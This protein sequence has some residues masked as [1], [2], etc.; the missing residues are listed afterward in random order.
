MAKIRRSLKGGAPFCSVVIAAAGSS[1]RMDGE[2]KLFTMVCGAPVLAY[3]IGAFAKSGLVNEIIV[4]ARFDKLEQAGRLCMDYGGGKATKVITGGATRLDSVL[5]GVLA[6]SKKAK[7]IAVH[8]GAR[9][10]VPDEVVEHA[11]TAAASRQAVAPAVK[12]VSTLKRAEYRKVL[13]TVDRDKLFEIQTPQVFIS[14]LIKAAL[15]NAVNKVAAVTDDCMAV[16]LMGVPVYLTEGSRSNIK[17]TTTED[18]VLIEAILGR[19]S[20]Y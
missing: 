7:L 17:L 11:I 8:D 13:E 4:V 5:N 9:P 10:C 18:L 16:E 19:R 14:E 15:T 2:D 12:I 20:G 3:S 1:E 6:V